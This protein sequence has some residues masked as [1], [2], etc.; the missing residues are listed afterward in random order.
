MKFWKKWFSPAE[1]GEVLPSKHDGEVVINIYSP[2][3]PLIPMVTELEPEVVTIYDAEA[4]LW[5]F[6]RAENLI[7]M[8]GEDGLV[9][10]QFHVG[11]VKDLV[12]ELE[13]LAN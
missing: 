9:Q 12:A 8:S 1:G 4:G 13:Q 7:Y 10:A 11:A 5:E 6:R 2:S 3:E